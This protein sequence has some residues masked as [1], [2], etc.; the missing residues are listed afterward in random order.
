MTITF[1]AAK[2]ED[3][4]LQV[5]LENARDLMDLLQIGYSSEGAIAADE[6]RNKIAEARKTLKVR[7]CEFTRPATICMNHRGVTIIDQGL[8]LERLKFYLD[9]LDEII[10]ESK[11]ANRRFVPWG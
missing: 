2:D 3:L 7:A 10:C 11:K 6:F 5:S 8:S 9:R 4:D 1:F